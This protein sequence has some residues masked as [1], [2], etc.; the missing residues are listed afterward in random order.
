MTQARQPGLDLDPTIETQRI[1]DFLRT[2]LRRPPRHRGY[3]VGLSGG[4]D[5]A[6]TAALARAAVG[7]SG[8]LG[9][10]LP[11][12]ESQPESRVLGKELAEAL[13]I[14]VIEEDLTGV[15]TSL[16]VYER[17]EAIVKSHVRDFQPGWRYRL[18]LPGDLRTSPQLNVYHLEVVDPESDVRRARLSLE[19]YRQIQ[20]A[21][22]VKQRLRMLRLYEYAERRAYLV[23]GTTNRTELMQGFFVR[24]GDGGVDLEP[25]AHLYKTQVYA[26][27]RHLGVPQA[28][29]DR[30]PSPDTFSAPV[31]DEE[32]YF[33]LPYPELDR[34]LACFERGAPAE[35]AARESGVSP[36]DAVRIY[37]ELTRRMETT[38]SLRELPPTIPPEFE[39]AGASR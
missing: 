29:L 3:V 33:R 21:T 7:E 26:L 16:G 4:V 28:I 20:A 8:V 38:R 5:S 34:M 39:T 9:V 12:R 2:Q 10:L 25:L 22:S 18:C 23:C 24:Y 15:L 1:V 11:E 19:E 36:E 30:P 14:E 35:A 27:A 13:G 17:R 32:F 6:L 31:S 37:K